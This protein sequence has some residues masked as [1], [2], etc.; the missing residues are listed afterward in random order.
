MPER[1]WDKTKRPLLNLFFVL[2][3]LVFYEAGVLLVGETSG[4]SVRSAA[5][6]WLRYT[7]ASMGIESTWIVP[8][9]VVGILL[10]WQLYA[11]DEWV[12][13]IPALLGMT[14]ESIGLGAALVL[15]GE[16]QYQLFAQL[17][18]PATAAMLQDLAAQPW[19]ADTVAYLGAGIYEETIFRLMLLPTTVWV[20]S[21]LQPSPKLASALGILVSAGVFSL[22]H[23][24]GPG[25]EA[26]DVFTF[27][28]RLIAGLF[29]SVVF[30][31]RGFGIAVG[32][33][34]AYDILVA[35]VGLHVLS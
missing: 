34:A 2:P 16:V 21:R 24:V 11:K 17:N 31:L 7:F 5:D 12:L 8:G 32:A 26:F 1:Y 6:A 3:L 22:A 33:H 9:L 13:D 35:V 18:Q 19:F 29:F 14:L 25:A 15:L 20:V 28:F 30:V 27:T 10:G 23:Y 4:Y